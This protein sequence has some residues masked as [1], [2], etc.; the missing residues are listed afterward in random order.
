MGVAK[1]GTDDNDTVAVGRRAGEAPRLVLRFD[2]L[3][4]EDSDDTGRYVVM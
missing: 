1:T 4:G 3:F 2:V